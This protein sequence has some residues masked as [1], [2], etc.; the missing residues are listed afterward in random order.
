MTLTTFD[1]D[2]LSIH[3]AHEIVPG[4][5]LHVAAERASGALEGEEVEIVYEVEGGHIVQGSTQAVY[6]G[7]DGE[8]ALTDIY[9]AAATAARDYKKEYRDYHSRPGQK[10]NRAA[11]NAARA[12]KG[13]AVGDKREVDHKKPLSKGG[14]N[15]SD[16]LRVVS[17]ET[18]RS[19]SDGEESVAEMATELLPVKGELSRMVQNGGRYTVADARRYLQSDSYVRFDP[20]D[21]QIAQVLKR[22]GG[23]KTGGAFVFEA[24]D[25]DEGINDAFILKA[26]F[27]TGGAGAGKSLIAQEMFG[28]TGLKV[29]NSDT[30]LETAMKKAG[31]DP[32]RDMSL[33]RVQEPGGLRDRAKSVTTRQLGSYVKGRLGLIIDSTAAKV[34]KVKKQVK[35]LRDLGYDCYMVFVNTSLKTALARNADRSRTVPVK[36]ATADWNK[37]QS[38][39]STYRTLFGPAN[40]R[41]INND[42]VLSPREVIARLTPQ[43]TRTAMPLLNQP[44][45]NPVGKAWIESQQ[46]L[47]VAA[48][49]DD[50][51]EPLSED[52]L[53]LLGLAGSAVAG[54]VLSKI[55][56]GAKRT[57]EKALQLHRQGKPSAA[58][59]A[60]AKLGDR[61][62][63]QIEAIFAA[64]TARMKRTAN[65]GAPFPSRSQRGG[66]RAMREH[67]LAE[68]GIG[69]VGLVQM[70]VTSM[71]RGTLSD[72]ER[73]RQLMTAG[74]KIDRKKAEAVLAAAR[75]HLSPTAKTTSKHLTVD[76]ARILGEAVEEVVFY[77]QGPPFEGERT[78]IQMRPVD[79]F[80]ENLSDEAVRGE[81]HAA[82]D[83]EEWT[84]GDD[85]T[86]FKEVPFRGETVRATL[87][88]GESADKLNEV[89]YEVLG[90]ARGRDHQK[91]G[92]L[93]KLSYAVFNVFQRYWEGQGDEL[94]AVLSRRGTSVDWV[95]LRASPA[96][97]R[98]LKEVAKEIHDTSDDAGEVRTAK[99]LIA[100]LKKPVR[101]S[102]D[103]AR[104]KKKFSELAIGDRFARAGLDLAYEKTSKNAAKL[105]RH[106]GELHGRP[107][108]QAPHDT[109][110]LLPPGA[111][112]GN[113]V[114]RALRG[115]SLDE[116]EDEELLD[117]LELGLDELECL[118]ME[119]LSDALA[120][121]IAEHSE[122][123]HK[124]GGHFGEFEEAVRCGN[125]EQAELLFE[126]IVE[127][128][129]L[130][131]FKRM[132]T[133]ARAA[134]VR[135]RRRGITQQIKTGKK[136]KGEVR[137][138]N[139]LRR[140][141]RRRS[142]TSRMKEQRKKRK[143]RHFDAN[144]RSLSIAK[145]SLDEALW[146]YAV[147]TTFALVRVT[148]HRHRDQMVQAFGDKAI[149]VMAW[150]PG[151]NVLVARKEAFAVKKTDLAAEI[152]KLGKG[153]TPLRR[154]P[155]Q[156]RGE[157][158]VGPWMGDN[159]R[160]HH[161]WLKRHGFKD[162]ANPNESLPEHAD[163]RTYWFYTP[164]GK[165]IIASGRGTTEK[166]A[167]ASAIRGLKVTDPGPDGLS[168][169]QQLSMGRYKLR[170]FEG[171]I[172][173]V[174]G[175]EGVEFRQAESDPDRRYHDHILPR[176]V[177]DDPLPHDSVSVVPENRLQP[178]PAAAANAERLRK[179]AAERKKIKA[180]LSRRKRKAKPANEEGWILD[181]IVNEVSPPGW[182]A[183]VKK[184]KRDPDIDNPW[185]LAWY[186]YNKEKKGGKREST[187]EDVLIGMMVTLDGKPSKVEDIGYQYGRAVLTL[188][189][190]RTV[191]LHPDR[192]SAVALGEDVNA[193]GIEFNARQLLSMWE[194]ED[195]ATRGTFEEWRARY[196]T[197]DE[198]YQ[199]VHWRGSKAGVR[200]KV[201][202]PGGKK[203]VQGRTFGGWIGLHMDNKTRQWVA[204]H[205]PT[206]LAIAR[207][208]FGEV[209]LVRR[210]RGL[211]DMLGS[212]LDFTDPADAAPEVKSALQNLSRGLRESL[213]E[214]L[215]ARDKKVI[216]AFVDKQAADGR[217]LKTDGTT[218]DFGGIGGVGVATWERNG[219]ISLNDTGSSKD[220]MVHRAIRKLAPR[221]WIDEDEMDEHTTQYKSLNDAAHYDALYGPGS[222][223]IWYAKDAAMRDF[224]M[225]LDFLRRH[226]P[227]KVPTRATYKKS[228]VR[229]GKIKAN[230]P[231]RIFGMMQGERWSP[232]GE[233]RTMLGKLGIHHT[234]MSIGDIVK[235]GTKVLFVD[236]DGFTELS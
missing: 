207:T 125:F 194:D 184:M 34:E 89:T 212:K 148:S 88:V 113:A 132:T 136:S 92:K 230:R 57:V 219:K 33:S 5:P 26:V 209:S 112:P 19:K 133:S 140:M 28:G 14:D 42:E 208:E 13:L 114:T 174:T 85:G 172:L 119:D 218:L 90:E 75:K 48:S 164:N 27:M 67:E 141:A 11:R 232:E 86:W 12:E 51:G 106:N 128:L 43:L 65:P 32:R 53:L 111:T 166:Q 80:S 24:T 94:Y 178:S 215:S 109:V 41:E 142:P 38:N 169:R 236:R 77:E 68:K 123:V 231:E 29:V 216:A 105:V 49:H 97:I 50:D 146:G 179:L 163:D 189:N 10:K 196:F 144:R 115:E 7:N 116:A 83:A 211:E 222:T 129:P 127:V 161:T 25:A 162:A 220:D 21:K 91:G 225:G 103:E 78:G 72:G 107:S 101:E 6:V 66:V 206:G 200:F 221:N 8:I 137:R 18:N 153:Y 201:A 15:D 190:G 126:A 202:M 227:G 93:I 160:D 186:L 134:R 224:V 70:Q 45:K 154:K 233:A 226:D 62:R 16:N 122:D 64:E 95:T 177:Q 188:A 135:S 171:T 145:E 22:L 156:M 76:I 9:E 4:S 59:M 102:L 185:R 210:V 2:I 74:V 175:P 191:M 217:A 52:A 228:H 223:E 39:L 195:E 56:I 229:I 203:T 234:S 35:M 82:L 155:A 176:G 17:R 192:A 46:R 118:F 84:E 1:R 167:L 36:V 31:L 187:D 151:E 81:L 138:E 150:K 181:A 165:T 180:A 3:Y 99:S 183:R 158:V 170:M 69:K 235:I 121:A 96:E 130:D 71:L 110:I 60:M 199:H 197:V 54:A 143:R 168:K 131:E 79:E 173:Q 61:D 152:A 73:V 47:A 63:K 108:R 124:V 198:G 20:S 87:K 205:I 98:R 58:E 214:A 204:T 40:F 23:R 213:D 193:H 157:Y 117:E 139:R 104:M 37:V 182:E 55:A 149:S 44:V 120:W 147:P 30:H 100:D 159:T